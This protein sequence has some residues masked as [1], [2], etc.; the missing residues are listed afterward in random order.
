MAVIERPVVSLEFVGADG[1]TKVLKDKGYE[2]QYSYALD[3]GHCDRKVR[4]QTL[5]QALEWVWHGYR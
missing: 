2:Y 5:P 3:S 1:S 4:E